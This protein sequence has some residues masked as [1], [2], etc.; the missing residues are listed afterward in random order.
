MTLARRGQF[1]IKRSAWA[2]TTSHVRRGDM[3]LVGP[4][5]EDPRYVALYT[6]E[7]RQVLAVRPGITSAAS[8]AYRHEELSRC[9]FR[10]LTA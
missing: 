10:K 5:P 6:P 3:S 1:S 7:Q 8:F 2:R 4:R 9:E